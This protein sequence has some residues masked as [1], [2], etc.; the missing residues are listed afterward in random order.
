MIVT[1]DLNLNHEAEMVFA[2]FVHCKV[3]LFLLSISHFL[4]GSHHGQP[5]WNGSY[6]SPLEAQCLHKLSGI[7]LHERF[8]YSPHLLIYSIIYLY[9]YELIGIYFILW[10]I[11]PYHFI[12]LRGLFHLW[13]F[14]S[15][16]HFYTHIIKT[17]RFS[18]FSFIFEFL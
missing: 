16:T 2:N 5:L 15:S 7:L 10:V 12:L 1:V 17:K 13:P 4:E 8:V 6:A 9:E 18:I 3:I 14:L 11:I